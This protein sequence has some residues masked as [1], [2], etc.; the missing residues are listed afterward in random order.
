M[1]EPASAENPVK[2]ERKEKVVM[3]DADGKP[4]SKK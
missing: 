1:S 3:L 4:L 2:Y